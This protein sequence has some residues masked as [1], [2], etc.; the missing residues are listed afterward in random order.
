MLSRSEPSID[1]PFNEF[2]GLLDQIIGVPMVNS[3]VVENV[4]T[5]KPNQKIDISIVTGKITGIRV[6]KSLIRQLDL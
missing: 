1:S 3:M 6:S 2:V 5:D 4:S